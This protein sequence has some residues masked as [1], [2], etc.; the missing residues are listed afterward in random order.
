MD[1]VSEVSVASSRTALVW[2]IC[3][4]VFSQRFPGPSTLRELEGG[5]GNGGDGEDGI[6]LI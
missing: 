5:E 4:V 3:S 1:N 2:P 6:K